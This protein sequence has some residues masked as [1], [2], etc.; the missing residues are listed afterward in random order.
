MTD[1]TTHTGE[2]LDTTTADPGPLVVTLPADLAAAMWHAV[3][4]V[5]SRERAA[6]DAVHVATGPDGVTFTACDTFA[7]HRVTIPRHHDA[8]HLLPFL[9][10]SP[11][12]LPAWKPADVA[13][14]AKGAVSV[15]F[16]VG[17]CGSEFGTCEALDGTG[18]VLATLTGPVADVEMWPAVETLFD[19]AG[20]PE[21][22]AVAGFCPTRLARTMTAASKFRGKD[23]APVVAESVQTLKPARFT[24]T[25]RDGAHFHAVLM[26]QKLRDRG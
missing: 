25:R 4:V 17:K 10:H 26:P 2:Q 15:R 14:L 3:A 12:N 18:T 16:T 1:T 5:S 13:R 24:L 19:A 7:L 23:G 22:G 8:G 9:P 21:D 6:L 20:W 11:G